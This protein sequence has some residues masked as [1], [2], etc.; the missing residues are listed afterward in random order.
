M[1]YLSKRKFIQRE[2]YFTIG[3]LILIP[4][5]TLL[6]TFGRDVD[7]R[8]DYLG[9]FKIQAAGLS[10]ILFVWCCFRQEWIKAFLFCVLIILNG[11]LIASHS[12][13]F[14]KRNQ[15][16]DAHQ[17]TVTYQ[18]LS[19]SENKIEKIRELIKNSQADLIVLTHVSKETYRHLNEL[20]GQYH[21]QNQ[22][23]DDNGN[24][25][26]IL[27]KTPSA[28]RG[29]VFKEKGLWVSRIAGTRKITLITADFQN[30]WSKEAYIK[31]KKDIYTIA[32]FIRGRD[33]PVILMGNFNAT[34]W[35]WLLEDL[36]THAQLRLQ[37]EMPSVE[38][39][40]PFYSR[41]PTSHIYTHRGIEVDH[42][43]E[44]KNTTTPHRAITVVFKI[45]PLYP[46]F[47]LFEL[48][49]ILPQEEISSDQ[50]HKELP[51]DRK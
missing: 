15:T 26:L 4:V 25:N 50:E 2:H 51:A 7:W 43:Q 37:E 47:E 41:R 38:P 18:N 13:F 42:I 1:G 49:P 48:Q 10:F 9:E 40:K 28:D 32:D 33:E 34:G 27:A 14:Q 19:G 46:E 22:Q 16:Q 36:G 23:Q 31:A 8:L 30:P 12:H 21:L 6:G 39:R 3:L 29:Q 45:A 17:F 20:I 11:A 44:Q 5:L 24:L 35:S